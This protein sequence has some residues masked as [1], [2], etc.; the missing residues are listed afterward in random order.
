LLWQIGKI[1]GREKKQL[2]GERAKFKK[3]FYRKKPYAAKEKARRRQT[4]CRL[5]GGE[6]NEGSKLSQSKVSP[7]E[8]TQGTVR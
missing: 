6:D 8:K 4:P 7:K 2:R 1:W 3:R 5:N